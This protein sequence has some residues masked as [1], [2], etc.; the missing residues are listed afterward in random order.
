MADLE[1]TALTASVAPHDPCGPDLDAVED[2]DYMN[3]MVSSETILPADYVVYSDYVGLRQP[4]YL[5]RRYKNLDLG[6]VATAAEPFLGRTRD[7][8]LLVLVAK[9]QVLNKRL[10]AFVVLVERGQ[11][12]EFELALRLRAQLAER[13][14]AYMLPR[15]FIFYDTFPI[16]AN[17]KTDRRMLATAIA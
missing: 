16:T 15:K 17:G 5:D 10:A 9:L 14:P 6:A 3:F 2:D 8:R 4:F 7:L 13:V 1:L 11:E 12:S